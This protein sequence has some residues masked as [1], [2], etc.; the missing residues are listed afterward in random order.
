MVD[1]GTWMTINL[2]GEGKCVFA[3]QFGGP[4]ETCYPL[5]LATWLSIVGATVRRCGMGD[6]GVGG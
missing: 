3:H 1:R 5:Y 6:A 2:Y 4:R